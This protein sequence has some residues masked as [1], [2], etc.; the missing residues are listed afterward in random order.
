MIFAEVTRPDSISARNCAIVLPTTSYFTGG[1]GN[2][3]SRGTGA[4]A[5]SR[6]GVQAA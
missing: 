1:V 6:V 2:F 3:F 4:W 5:T